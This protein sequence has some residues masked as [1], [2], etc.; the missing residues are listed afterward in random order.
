MTSW[1]WILLADFASFKPVYLLDNNP[2]DYN[3]FF[4]TSRRRNCYIA[5]ERFIKASNSDPAHKDSTVLNYLELSFFTHLTPEMDIFSAGCAIL[6]LWND[7]QATFDYSQL[8]D[9]RKGNEDIVQQRFQKITDDNLRNMITSMI[10]LDPKKRK[11]AEIY[12][13]EMRKVLFPEYFYTFLQS[14]VQIFSSKTADEKIGSLYPDIEQIKDILTS[15]EEDGTI[16][17]TS[18]VTS[19]IRGLVRYTYCI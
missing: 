8:L 11:S 9:Y 3:Y 2:A 14:F 16:L 15:R 7:G 1:N 17:L 18:I 10:S 4:D 12:L 5:P 19:C 13:S 6:E